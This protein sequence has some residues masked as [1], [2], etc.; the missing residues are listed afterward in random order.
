MKLLMAVVLSLLLIGAATNMNAQVKTEKARALDKRERSIVPIAA[1]TATGDLKK[2]RSAMN[3]G[4]DAGLTVNEIKEVLAQMYAYAGF[5]RALNGISTFMSVI[6]ER[7]NR[8]VKDTEGRSSAPMTSGDRYERGRKTLEK[9]TGQ[10]QAKPAPGFGE[11]SPTIDRFLKEH[12]FADIFDSDVLTY[13]QRELAT[14]SALAAMT[15]VVPQ[16]DAHI[17]MGMNTGL[18]ESQLRAAFDLVESSV[19]KEQADIAR[20]LLAKI[21]AARPKQSAGTDKTKTEANMQDE[22]WSGIFPKGERAPT[23]WFTG[24]VW[25]Q[26][27]AQKTG[28]NDYSLGS[29]T[30]EP[31]ARSNWHTHPAGQ[32]LVVVDGQG[33]YQERGKA[34]RTINKGET[35]VC[36][37]NIE[38]WHG[39]TPNSRMTHIAITNDKG[40]GG[41]NWLA[42]VTN[43]E[44]NVSG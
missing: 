38:H 1:L 20:R 35:I 11:F 23:D 9:L 3:N 28:G 29:V 34:V 43:A 44:Y 5:P 22:N 26:M 17:S 12:L 13:R 30:F 4:L 27:L 15:G 24:T 40:S 8:A 21:A 18:T 41:V 14:I 19:N 39:A 7:K 37:P 10:P 25:L 6:D 33:L 42:P 36:D 31:G 32:T 16:L 2:L